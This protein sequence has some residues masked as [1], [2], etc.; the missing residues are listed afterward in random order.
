MII[1]NVTINIEDSVEQAWLKWMQDVHIPDVLKTGLFL[2][3]RI[4]RL[5][6]EEE[7]GVTYTFQY[8]ANSI[9]DYHQYQKEH[10]PLLQKEHNDRFKDKFVAFRSLMEVI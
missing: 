10:A 9:D 6:L 8:T 7:T 4:C 3:C 2:D 1:Y 5:L